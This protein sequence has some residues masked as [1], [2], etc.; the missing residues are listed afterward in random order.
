[1]AEAISITTGVLSDIH[2]RE[3]I[4]ANVGDIRQGCASAA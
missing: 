4:A 1:V 2:I 3:L